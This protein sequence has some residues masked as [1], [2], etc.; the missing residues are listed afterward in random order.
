VQIGAKRGGEK[1][2]AEAGKDA[3]RRFSTNFENS[4]RAGFQTADSR[5]QTWIGVDRRG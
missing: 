2:N 5:G 1:F 3:R 4:E